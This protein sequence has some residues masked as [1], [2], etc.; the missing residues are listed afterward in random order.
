MG[1][2]R[3][4]L[5]ERRTFP[6]Y[7]PKWP[8]KLNRGFT[9]KR[10]FLSR[11]VIP[12]SYRSNFRPF[13]LQPPY[14]FLS[15]CSLLL[16]GQVAELS[17]PRYTAKPKTMYIGSGLCSFAP[18]SGVFQRLE[19]DCLCEMRLPFLLAGYLTLP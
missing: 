15:F 8:R 6:S 3:P 18:S 16:L 1:R 10:C 7:G 9:H 14:A 12:G 5:F 11:F 19:L 4:L 2:K 13:N 17:L